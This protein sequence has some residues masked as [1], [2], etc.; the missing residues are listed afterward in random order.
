[1]KI[2]VNQDKIGI[3]Q[4]VYSIASIN[5]IKEPNLQA[6]PTDRETENLASHLP[7][8]SGI[9]R[10]FKYDVA[11]ELHFLKYCNVLH[12]TALHYCTALCPALNCT[13]LNC[14]ALHCTALLCS[15]LHCTVL[16]CTVLH[17]TVLYCTVLYCTAL[18][19]SVLYCTH[20]TLL[21]YVVYCTCLYE[22]K[23]F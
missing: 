22:G 23:R 13:A 4:N 7:F 12:C 1:V 21:Y 11:S 15:A 19:Y 17:C 8:C 18:Y 2:H 10:C 16:H 6:K 3:V 20:C 9:F 5:Q 14:T